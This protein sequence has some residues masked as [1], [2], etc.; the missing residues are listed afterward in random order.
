MMQL[1]VDLDGVLADFDRGYELAFGTR[2]DKTVD[3]V[4]WSLIEK[5]PNFYR[6]LPPMSDAHELWTFVAP[7]RPIILTG[8]PSSIQE[9]ADNK[10][11]WVRKN[12]GSEVEVRCCRSAEKYLH[13]A[14]GDIL[15]DD[16]E[17][18]RSLWIAQGGAWITHTSA[19]NTIIELK[20]LVYWC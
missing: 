20:K 14:P 2:P 15:I 13:A 10:T 7:R 9:A 8:I 17:K 5:T 6:D 16:W 1:F 19:A 12:L 11:A 4:K 18:Y 3:N